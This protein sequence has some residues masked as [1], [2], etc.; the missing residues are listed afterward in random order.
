MLITAH[1]PETKN[2]EKTYL[3]QPVSSGDT[4]LNV[5]N[6]D[7]FSVNDFV[8][9]GEMGREKSEVVQVSA[10]TDSSITTGATSFAHSA[11]DPIHKMRFNQIRFYRSTDGVDGSY[12]VIATLDVD[13]DNADKTT[14]YDDDTATTSYFYKTAFYNSQTTTES[15]LSDPVQ[16]TGY[17]YDTVGAVVDETV[18]YLGDKNYIVMSPT[19]YIDIINDVGRDI[20]RNTRKPL[21]FLKTSTTLDTVKDQDYVDL[22]ADFWKYDYVEYTHTVGANDNTYIVDTTGTD[23][24]AN[25]QGRDTSTNDRLERVHIDIADNRLY[26]Y[27]TPRT[28]QTGKIK[29]HYYK[30]FTRVDSMGDK[31]DLKDTNIYKLKMTERFYALKTAEDHN[32]QVLKDD[33]KADYSIEL[34]KL[35]REN[36]VEVGGAKN[37]GSHRRYWRWHHTKRRR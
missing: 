19:E 12:S 11:D 13:V 18:R 9:I 10:V 30:K 21:R 3:T 5:L 20:M 23:F 1:N 7:N 15:S 26:L 33:A 17:D 22:P 16:A 37:F 24:F 4:V 31:L 32:F 2:A 6:S 28:S 36:K 35:K 8:L 34:Q 27:P 14:K 25:L 29:L